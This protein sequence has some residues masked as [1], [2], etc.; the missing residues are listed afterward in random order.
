MSVTILD[1]KLNVVKFGKEDKKL[2]RNVPVFRVMPE[3]L[4]YVAL[5]F[6]EPP[7]LRLEPYQYT[8]R[9][10][11]GLPHAVADETTL[12]EIKWLQRHRR[13]GLNKLSILGRSSLPATEIA[14]RDKAKIVSAVI[15]MILSFIRN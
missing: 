12:S 9:I 7:L 1:S 14:D 13:V 4:G 5:N 2:I 6:F 8:G 10:G 3:I 11:C 15:V